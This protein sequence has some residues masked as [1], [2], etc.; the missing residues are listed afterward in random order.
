MPRQL[1]PVG[2][3]GLA[4]TPRPAA[5]ALLDR[6][7]KGYIGVRLITGDHPVTATAIT[8]ELGLAVTETR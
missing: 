6:A 3:L 1:T 2:L 4:D 8:N 7:A 5:G